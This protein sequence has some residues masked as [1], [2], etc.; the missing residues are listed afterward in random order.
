MQKVDLRSDTLTKPTPEMR[1]AIFNAQVGDDVFGEDPTI[2]ELQETIA[3][4]LGKEAAL[5]VSSGTMANQIAI[6]CHTN[7]GE[8]VI[9]EAGAH[10]F[11][12]EAGAPAMLSGVQIRQIVGNRGV[13]TADQIKSILLPA[14][15]H[16]ARQTLVTIEN[17]HN[18][19]GG[20]VFPLDEILKIRALLSSAGIKF[21]MDGARLWN[22]SIA[23]GIA[24][25]TFAAPF[26][27]VS[28]CLSKG[29]GAP[30]G[31][32][33][34]GDKTFIA[35]ARRYRKAYGGGMRQAGIL[36]AAG[37]YAVRHHQQRLQEDHQRA[38][39]LAQALAQYPG[40]NIDLDAVQTNI[41]YANFKKTGKVAQ[42]I[43]D[44][45]SA[46][47]L[48]TLA[49]SLNEIRMVTH[50]DVNDNDID[51]AIHVFDIVLG[52]QG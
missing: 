19:A 2:N 23:T 27:S 17:T 36:A 13:F 49:T 5:F 33:L 52:E 8:E 16:Y 46:H 9:C 14:N 1:Q 24:L 37:L 20:T 42:K 12:Y 51:W 40:V 48:Y 15:D 30:V 22:A 6:N 10:I 25:K 18:R 4:L 7:P 26:D 21:H 44:E 31:S 38:K 39:K 28:V 29:L 41:L 45:F 43:V 11:N 50:L 3:D 32:L 35:Q 34:A 47:G